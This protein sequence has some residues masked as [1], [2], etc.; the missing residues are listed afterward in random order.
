MVDAHNPYFVGVLLVYVVL[1]L[2][3]EVLRYLN[4]EL[5]AELNW[6]Q[7]I[8]PPS[9]PATPTTPTNFKRC[10]VCQKPKGEDDF[11]KKQ[12]KARQVR[13]C[14]ACATPAAAGPTPDQTDLVERLRLAASQRSSL[15]AEA[16]DEARRR[17]LRRTHRR[18][19]RAERAAAAREYAELRAERRAERDRFERR[20]TAALRAVANNP[21]RGHFHT[22][23]SWSFDPVN[24]TVYAS[25]ANLIEHFRVLEE[26]F[27][28]NLPQILR[29]LQEGVHILGCRVVDE[30]PD[31]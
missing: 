9:T 27:G 13:R 16:E 29:Q 17:R 6:P 18:A 30:V 24:G 11:S 28:P 4:P 5:V 26:A 12:W 14:I 3:V 8:E 22:P 25:D 15:D 10:S 21:R 31:H 2:S 23:K 1:V 19:E 7:L 20:V